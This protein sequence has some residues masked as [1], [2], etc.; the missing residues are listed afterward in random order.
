M[1]YNLSYILTMNS[2]LGLQAETPLSFTEGTVDS[3]VIE[4]EL[5]ITLKTYPYYHN[6][7]NDYIYGV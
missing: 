5:S 2:W 6:L 1:E 3:S 7:A 4:V